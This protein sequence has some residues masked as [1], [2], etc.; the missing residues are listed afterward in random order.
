MLQ[1]RFSTTLARTK[2]KLKSSSLTSI[3]RKKILEITAF[4]CAHCDRRFNQSDLPLR[5]FRRGWIIRNFCRWYAKQTVSARD[6]VAKAARLGLPF[7]VALP[8]YRGVAGYG[9]D[10]KLLSVA[11]DSV[12]PSWPPGTR[13]LE[14]GAD[15]DE[16]AALVD[17]WQKA[18]PTQ[19][20]ELLWYRMPIGTDTRNWRWVTLSAVMAGRRPEHNLRVLQEG[21]NPIDLSILNAGEADERVNSEVMATWSGAGLD[22][23]DAL[24]GW[25]VRSENGHAFFSAIEQRGVRLPPGAICKIGWL[26]FDQ[27]TSLRTEFSNQSESLH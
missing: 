23:A 13:I 2:S 5:S 21:A 3:A 7:S 20:R 4:G 18:R 24:A 1:K 10:G 6:W 19:L 25:S 26:R 17:A 12:Q 22:A 11:M 8:T 27:T 14:F 9:P 15:A 16:I